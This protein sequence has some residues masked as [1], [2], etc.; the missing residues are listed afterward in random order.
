MDKIKANIILLLNKYKVYILAILLGIFFLKS[1]GKSRT[2]SKFERQ[3][4]VTIE[5]IDS[6]K[7]VIKSQQSRL[8]SFP[9][10]MRNEKL[11][12]YL[13]LDDKISRIDRGPQMMKLHATIKD[14][15]LTLK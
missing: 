7:Y 1:C 3:E 8:D 9:E 6:I 11:S 15:I 13:D 5:L 10:I 14:S 4:I 12:V 2:I